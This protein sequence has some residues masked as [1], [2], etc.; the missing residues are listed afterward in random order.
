[1]ST[2]INYLDENWSVITG[3]T[4]AGSPGCDNCYARVSH[5]RRHKAFLAGKKMPP[6]YAH[7]FSKVQFHPDRLD[8]PLHWRKPR[9]VGVVFGG[10]LFHGDVNEN[11]RD[12]IFAAMLLAPEHKYFLLTKRAGDMARYA[13]NIIAGER[14]LASAAAY[15]LGRGILG[16]LVIKSA[17]LGWPP[18][19]VYHGATCCTQ[20]ELDRNGPTMRGVPGKWWLSLEPLLGPV[21]FEDALGTDWQESQWRPSFVVVGS[22]SGPNRRPCKLEWILS[23]VEQCKAA[24]VPCWVKQIPVPKVRDAEWFELDYSKHYFNAAQWDKACR[25]HG[26]RVS[27][28]MAEWP[29]ALRVRSMP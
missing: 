22:E 29:E 6:Q 24:G 5:E 15:E 1:M 10:D 8:A 13:N 9:N 20:P 7:P 21:C 23:I 11:R 2:G 12:A 18:E 17:L 14:G 3:C 25:Q 26:W 28:D 4:H 27:H 16:A 19:H